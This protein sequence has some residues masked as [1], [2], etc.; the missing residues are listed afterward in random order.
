VLIAIAMRL[1]RAVREGDLVAR[2][3]AILERKGD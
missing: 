1:E 2:L 3:P